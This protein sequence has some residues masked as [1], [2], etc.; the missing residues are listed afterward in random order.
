MADRAH[1]TSVEAL[2]SFR[3][4]LV[5]YLS[6]VRPLLEEVGSDLRRM[7]HWL[8]NDQRLYWER[9]IRLRTRALEQAQQALLSAR[10]ATF[11]DSSVVE[12]AAVH[13]ARRALEDAQAR[14]RRLRQWTR[15]F[16]PRTESLARQV[17]SLDTVLGHDMAR[18]L[19][20]LAQAIGHLQAYADVRRDLAPPAT[21]AATATTAAPAGTPAA[22]ASSPEPGRESDGETRPPSP[23]PVP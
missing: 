8:E 1:V 14:Q 2:E 9:E 10:I 16:G 20:W 15:E 12:Q 3:T 7:Q 21:T 4:S 17:A 19:A 13:A 6:R 22:P 5:V 18:A 23:P 11:R